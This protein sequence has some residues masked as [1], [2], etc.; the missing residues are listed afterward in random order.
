MPDTKITCPYCECEG[1]SASFKGTLFF[2][3]VFKS[4]ETEVF[5]KKPFH[6]TDNK[7][8]LHN[9][10][11]PFHIVLSTKKTRTNESEQGCLK[12]YVCPGCY[13]AVLK[14]DNNTK[15]FIEHCTNCESYKTVIG[16]LQLKYPLEVQEKPKQTTPDAFE[17]ARN[18]LQSGSNTMDSLTGSQ[19]MVYRDLLKSEEG[20]K[21][22]A[23]KAEQEERR[24]KYLFNVLFFE[25]SVARAVSNAN[26]RFFEELQKKKKEFHNHTSLHIIDSPTIDNFFIHN[27]YYEH[28]E[29]HKIKSQDL[30]NEFKRY[31]T[32]LL[33]VEE[34]EEESG[35]ESTQE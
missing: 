18:N 32:S 3:H 27:K 21:Q 5:S 29:I 11:V 8:I 9:T 35:D 20:W 17:I 30:L 28:Y 34:P 15:S 24:Y 10:K 25:S 13:H 7:A 6:R 26:P 19:A 14:T 23:L 4:H 22:R 12:R 31:D 16:N 2:T 33:E 1:V